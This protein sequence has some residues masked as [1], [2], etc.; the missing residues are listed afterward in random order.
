MSVCESRHRGGRPCGPC[1]DEGFDGEPRLPGAQSEGLQPSLGCWGVGWWLFC[2]WELQ[3]LCGRQS[4]G[5]GFGSW[6]TREPS[7]NTTET[8]RTGVKCPREV[9]GKTEPHGVTAELRGDLG[10]VLRSSWEVGRQYQ[11]C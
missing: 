6:V 4:L 1:E 10:Q 9:P 2:T 7:Q 11:A 5:L 3:C 8:S